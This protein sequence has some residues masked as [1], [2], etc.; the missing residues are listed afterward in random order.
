MSGY[1]GT[2]MVIEVLGE[3]AV[4]RRLGRVKHHI[5]DWGGVWP[6]VFRHLERSTARQF[7]SEGAYGSGGWAALAPSTVAEKQAGGWPPTILERTGEMKDSFLVDDHPEHIAIAM[8]DQGWW[9]S[10]SAIA[11]YHQDGTDLMPQRRIIQ[12][13]EGSR[14]YMVRIMQRYAL[15]NA[16]TPIGAGA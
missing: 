4:A 5:E 14:A 8:R 12:P 3:K 1:A 9:G 16:P 7:A 10:S 2:D 6:E 11:H 15:A 13:P